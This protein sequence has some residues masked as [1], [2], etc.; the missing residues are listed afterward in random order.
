MTETESFHRLLT[1]ADTDLTTLRQRLDREPRLANTFLGWT[2]PWGDEQWMP[3]HIAAEAGREDVV[4]LLLEQG[5]SPDCR[6]RF[7]TPTQ[8]RQ[9]PLHLAAAHGHTAV[10][11]RL[12]EASAE[13][14]V[15]DAQQRSPLWLA[16]RYGHAEAAH[17]LLRRGAKIDIADQQGRTPLHAALLDLAG[18]EAASVLIEAG[19]DV[20]ATCPKEP[21]GYTPLHRCVGLGESALPILRALRQAG[22][23]V[24]LADPRHQ[25]TPA[26]LAA[27]LGRE[28]LAD[29]LA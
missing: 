9:T 14:D 2:R 22:A 17:G 13:V 29:V 11:T 25:R 5:V 12:L 26:S 8:A 18:L 24:S 15:R 23:D 21:D 16:A 3:L 4:A 7:V 28:A 1:A 27:H 6:T 19:A 10:V 20:N